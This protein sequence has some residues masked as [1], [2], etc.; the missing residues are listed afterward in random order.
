MTRESEVLVTSGAT[1]ALA[2]AIF[3]LVARGDEIVL[4]EP[5]YDAY[6]PIAESGG[7]GGE[8]HHLVAAAAGG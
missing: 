7:R 2:A 6:R 8:N 4:I 1:E 5:H 3:G